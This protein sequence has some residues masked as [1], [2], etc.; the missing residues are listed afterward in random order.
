M[1]FGLVIGFVD[2]LL[3]VTTNSYYTIADFHTTNH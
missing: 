2:Y 3:E 1:G